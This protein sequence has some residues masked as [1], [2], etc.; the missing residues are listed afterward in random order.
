MG[1]TV[2]VGFAATRYSIRLE[3]FFTGREGE[4]WITRCAVPGW[5]LVT[6]GVMAALWGSIGGRGRSSLSVIIQRG[7]LGGI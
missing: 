7:I 6:E 5:Y 2:A 3:D 4:R 1:W